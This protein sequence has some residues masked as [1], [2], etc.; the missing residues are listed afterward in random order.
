[1]KKAYEKAEIEIFVFGDKDVL[2]ASSVK[3]TDNDNAY[4]DYSSLFS[5]NDFFSS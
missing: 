1:M 5:F 4:V 3:P 2:T